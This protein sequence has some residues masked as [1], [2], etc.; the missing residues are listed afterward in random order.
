MIADNAIA[1]WH[2]GTKRELPSADARTAATSRVWKA[3]SIIATVSGNTAGVEP[4]HA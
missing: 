2:A 4:R 3:G 1:A